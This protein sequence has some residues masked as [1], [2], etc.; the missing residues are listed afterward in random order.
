MHDYK[1]DIMPL[2]SAQHNYESDKIHKFDA[3][4]Q[5]ITSSSLF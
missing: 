1:S 5:E 2:Q 3:T 4:V